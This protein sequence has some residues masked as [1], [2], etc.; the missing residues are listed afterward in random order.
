MYDITTTE[1]AEYLIADVYDLFE[2]SGY[3][4]GDVTLKTVTTRADARSTSD[5]K[6]YTIYTL[7]GGSMVFAEN[8]SR[9]PF[10]EN[11][12]VMAKSISEP[13]TYA[14]LWDIPQTSEYTLLQLLNFARNEMFARAGHQFP[15]GSYLRHFSSYDWYEPTGEKIS[16]TDLAAKW[17]V[18]GTNTSTIR[19]IENLIV[20]G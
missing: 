3:T 19:F 2:E 9:S 8:A 16:L 17:P 4:A 13:L 15:D 14:E 7:N 5:L 10:D 18:A 11:G 20:E 1:G 12:L 6:D